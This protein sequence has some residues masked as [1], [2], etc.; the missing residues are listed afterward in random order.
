MNTESRASVTLSREDLARIRETIRSNLFDGD[1]GGRV[2]MAIRNLL[3]AVIE[4]IDIEF[5]GD[6]AFTYVDEAF[7]PCR[8]GLN[9]AAYDPACARHRG[10]RTLPP[11][12]PGD[13]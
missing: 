7:P 3:D 8:C 1:E 5:N 9:G 13:Q 2:A 10:V 11:P 4:A 6:A 12:D